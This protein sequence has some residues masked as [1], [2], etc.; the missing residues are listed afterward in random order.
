M[1]PKAMIISLNGLRYGTVFLKYESIVRV[2]LTA[3]ETYKRRREGTVT[4]ISN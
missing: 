4:G 2:R 3:M 1:I